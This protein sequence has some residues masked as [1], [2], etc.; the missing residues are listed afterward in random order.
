M[1]LD[2][3]TLES[4]ILYEPTQYLFMGTI[5]LGVMKLLIKLIMRG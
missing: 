1:N 3:L 5:F 2:L 4:W